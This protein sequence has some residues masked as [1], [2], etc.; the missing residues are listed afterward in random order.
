VEGAERVGHRGGIGLL[1]H[2]EPGRAR[3]ARS[4]TGAASGMN[5]NLRTIGGSL[6]AAAMSGVVTAHAGQAWLPLESSYP[7]GSRCSRW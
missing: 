6:R 1:R 2:D 3:R 7:N 4:R 5:A